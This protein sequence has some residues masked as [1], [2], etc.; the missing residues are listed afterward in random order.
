VSST[1]ND[2]WSELSSVPLKLIVTV[3]PASADRLKVFWLYPVALFRFEKVART[4]L[5]ALTVS[6]SNWVVVV[7]SAVSMCSQ[8]V[9]V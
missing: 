2:V 6:L 8:K 9:N 1:T 3:W 7:V 4:V 5:P